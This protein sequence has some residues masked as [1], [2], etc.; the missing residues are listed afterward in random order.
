VTALT[1]GCAIETTDTG[2]IRIGN[3]IV[4]AHEARAI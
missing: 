3:V 4:P 1:L 2:D